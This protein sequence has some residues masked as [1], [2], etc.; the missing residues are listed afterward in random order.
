MQLA[1]GR[2]VFSMLDGAALRAAEVAG[3]LR[4]K[5]VI[6]VLQ[7]LISVHGAPSHLRSDNELLANTFYID[8]A[9]ERLHDSGMHKSMIHGQ[10]TVLPPQECSSTIV[11]TRTRTGVST[12]LNTSLKTR[13]KVQAL[14]TRSMSPLRPVRA[15]SFRRDYLTHDKVDTLHRV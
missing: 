4:S 3:S 5:H 13:R 12:A 8:W 2:E 15:G 14:S 7:R 10:T 1:D 6:G 9:R 11:D